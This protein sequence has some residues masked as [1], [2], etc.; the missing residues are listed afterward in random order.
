MRWRFAC[1]RLT[2]GTVQEQSLL[3]Q[4][5]SRIKGQSEREPEADIIEATHTPT[6][7]LSTWDGPLG[8][9]RDKGDRPL[10]PLI[11]SPRMW[12]VPGRGMILGKA[13]LFSRGLG[14]GL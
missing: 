12:A 8:F 7:D 11:N 5:G 6:G 2:E 10:Y 13:A 1:K 14:N 3:E 4:E 9:L